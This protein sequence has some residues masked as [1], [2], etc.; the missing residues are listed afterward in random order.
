MKKQ[1]N[2]FRS[3]GAGVVTISMV[4]LAFGLSWILFSDALVQKLFSD[5]NTGTITIIQTYKGLAYVI[6][7]TILLLFLVGGFAARL[8]LA[9]EQKLVC[10]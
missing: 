6:I 7:T 3:A 10:A 1:T 9:I 8:K 5:S 4:Y 2:I